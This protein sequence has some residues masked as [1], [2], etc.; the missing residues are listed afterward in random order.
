MCDTLY[1]RV[2]K[3]SVAM[4]VKP[5]TRTMRAPPQHHFFVSQKNNNSVIVEVK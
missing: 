2:E 5:C 1:N 4:I 3:T